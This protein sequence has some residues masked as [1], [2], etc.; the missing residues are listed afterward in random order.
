MKSVTLIA[1]TLAAAAML[2]TA[3]P[4][5][6]AGAVQNVPAFQQPSQLLET[7]AEQMLTAIESHRAEYRRHPTEVAP[8][9]DKYLLPH[10]DTPL[11]AQLVLGRFWRTA[12]P[13]QRAR[14][15]KA[16]HDSL[17]R[18]YG[19]AMAEFHSNMLKVYPTHVTPG[20]TVAT[21]RTNFTRSDGS[22]V[23]VDFYVHM[24]PQGWKAFDVVIDGI[25]YV[26]SYREDFGPQIEQQGLDAVIDHLEKGEK[27]S[28]IGAAGRG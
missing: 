23:H 22:K 16:F 6:A 15:I 17:I 1:A 11:A 27:P 10:F 12:T 25:S 13:Q 19:A 9:V 4:A 24:T 7:V 20:T 5:K 28:Q 14:F 3:P 26:K 18:N 21:V 2:Q 8:I